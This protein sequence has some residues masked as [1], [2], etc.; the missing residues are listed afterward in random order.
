MNATKISKYANM[1]LMDVS[2]L[3]VDAKVASMDA[4]TSWK[5]IARDNSSSYSHAD[6]MDRYS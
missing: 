1:Q 2:Y 3:F 5:Q 6:S 4:S